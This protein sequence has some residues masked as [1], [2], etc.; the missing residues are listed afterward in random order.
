MR[1][2]EAI[3]IEQATTCATLAEGFQK[4]SNWYLSR[5]DILAA[6]DR[7][8]EAEAQRFALDVFLATVPACT[9]C[10]APLAADTLSGQFAST[11]QCAPC[12]GWTA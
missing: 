2:V 8:H 6:W 7:Y 5:G 9:S 1:D 10:N 11:V 4:M 3:T 12:R